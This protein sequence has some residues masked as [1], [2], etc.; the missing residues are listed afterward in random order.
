MEAQDH[1][2]QEKLENRRINKALNEVRSEVERKTSMMKRQ[3][4]ENENTQK[5]MNSLGLKQEQAMTVSRC[6]R[7]LVALRFLSVLPKA[8]F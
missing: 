5:S 6:T 2:Q 8:V 7:V 1:L 4:E 3:R